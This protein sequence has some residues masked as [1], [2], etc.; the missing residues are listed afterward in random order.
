MES[1]DLF[2]LLHLQITGDL[3][4]ALSTTNVYQDV[5]RVNIINDAADYVTD[6][7]DPLSDSRFKTILTSFMDTTCPQN[8]SGNGICKEAVCKCHSGEIN[9]FTYGFVFTCFSCCSFIFEKE[10]CK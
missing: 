7:E 9:I 5:C 2:V 4:L 8:C 1:A 6:L 3:P 10:T